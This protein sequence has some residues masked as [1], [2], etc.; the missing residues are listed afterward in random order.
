MPGRDEA[1]DFRRTND[2]ENALQSSHDDRVPPPPAPRA[3]RPGDC[4]QAPRRKVHSSYHSLP[5]RSNEPPQDPS[6]GF[7]PR[8]TPHR[9]FPPPPDRAEA[10]TMQS[11]DVA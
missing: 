6:R 5:A 2:F 1:S 7:A 10:P 4:T 9:D 8:R 11:A 3:S